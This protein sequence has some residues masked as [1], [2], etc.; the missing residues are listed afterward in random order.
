MYGLPRNLDVCEY[1]LIRWVPIENRFQKSEICTWFKSTLDHFRSQILVLMLKVTTNKLIAFCFYLIFEGHQSFLQDHW[2]SCFW[3]LV[4]SALGFKTG[5]DPPTCVLHCVHAMESWDS[6]LVWHLL[7][8]WVPTWRP[9]HF[10][11]SWF[12]LVLKPCR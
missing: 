4:T 7:T 6:P 9:S 8:S 1:A 12:W 2:H 5:V 10:A 11:T 3:L